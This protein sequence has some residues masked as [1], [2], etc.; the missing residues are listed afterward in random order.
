MTWT[1]VVLALAAS[2]AAVPLAAADSQCQREGPR[3]DC[4]ACNMLV[5]R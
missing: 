3:V 4:G 5:A 2:L 1:V